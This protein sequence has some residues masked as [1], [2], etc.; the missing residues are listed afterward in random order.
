MSFNLRPATIEDAGTIAALHIQGWRDAYKHIVDQDY[1]DTLSLSEKTAEWQDWLAD[2]TIDTLFTEQDGRAL[3]FASF[4]KLRTP[5]PGM[6]PIRP[7]YSAE[8]YALYIHPDAW[9]QGLGKQ[10]M[11]ATA[12]TLAEKKHKSLCL[13]VADKNKPANFFYKALGGERCGKQDITVGPSSFRDVCYGWRKAA[14]LI[15]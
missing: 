15:S 8:L 14:I 6:S 9:R 12:E 3:G 13:W 7:L 5:P 4:G 11:A 10:L 1:L 2:E